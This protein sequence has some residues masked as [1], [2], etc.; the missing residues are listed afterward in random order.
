MIYPGYVPIPGVKYRV[1][2]YG[3]EFSVGNWSFDKAKW[4]NNDV[5]NKCWAKFPDPPD[6]STLDQSNEDSLQRD[7]LSIECA[8]SL[9]EGLRRYHVRRKCPDPNSMST[10][11]REKS[12]HPPALPSPNL[13]SAI[14]I[15][16]SKKFEKN[17]EIDASIRNPDMKNESQEKIVEEVD[18]S[19]EVPEVKIESQ[20][21]IVEKFDVLRHNAD[22]KNESQVLSP[23]AETNQTFTSM[24]LWIIGLWAISIVGFVVVMWM[25]ISRRKGQRKRGKSYKSKRRTSASGFWDMNGHDRHSRNAEI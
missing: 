5:V 4:R 10:P 18:D 6:P 9:N 12:P 23:P 22:L 15:T 19:R 1:F 20:E 16:S 14:E 2:H 13:E 3:L 21:K 8:N 11:T 24:R 7:L 25:M 17:D